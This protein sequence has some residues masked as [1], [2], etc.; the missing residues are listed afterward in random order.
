LY[1]KFIF[2]NFLVVLLKGSN[3]Y[4]HA[5][6]VWCT[7][8][9]VCAPSFGTLERYVYWAKQQAFFW[10]WFQCCFVV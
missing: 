3:I 10:C 6:L 8:Y 1:V 9:F 4:L 5:L 7:L 2:W